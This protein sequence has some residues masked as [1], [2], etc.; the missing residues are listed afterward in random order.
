[1]PKLSNTKGTVTPPTPQKM[2]GQA[3]SSKGK[4]DANKYNQ[5]NPG[6]K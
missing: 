5:Q 4:A 6:K 2:L 1:M 3:D